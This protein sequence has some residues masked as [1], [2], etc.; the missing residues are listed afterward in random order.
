MKNI[1]IKAINSLVSQHYYLAKGDFINNIY[2]N[3]NK[4]LVM[5]EFTIS[6]TE[7]STSFRAFEIFVRYTNQIQI[8]DIIGVCFGTACELKYFS[9]KLARVIKMMQR[10]I[11]FGDLTMKI[12]KAALGLSKLVPILP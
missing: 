10:F 2:T 4:V 1:F 12:I 9:K 5:P 7:V 8:S 3:R 6:K 11:L